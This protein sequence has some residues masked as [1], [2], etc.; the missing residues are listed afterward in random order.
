MKAYAVIMSGGA[1]TRFWPVSRERRPKQF[2]RLLS[3]RSLLRETYERLLAVVD[4]ERVY[5]A[6]GQRYAELVREELPEIPTSHI[7]AEP[8]GKNTLPCI[9]VAATIIGR[10]EKEAPVLFLPSDHH[11]DDAQGFARALG[12]ALEY[13]AREKGIL[14]IGMRPTR[15]ETG[16]GYIRAEEQVATAVGRI[17]KVDAFSEKPDRETAI[18]F[19]A[20][21]LH[22]WNSGIF[23]STPEVML[24]AIAR[25]KPRMS[26][27]LMRLARFLGT[28]GETAA[29]E[30]FYRDVEAVSIDYGI[31]EKEKNVYMVEGA[32]SWSDLGNW[33]SVHELS[34]KDEQGNAL[35][36]GDLLSIGSRGCCVFAPGRIVVM[37][38]VED[39]V[40]VSTDDALLVCRRDQCQ[41]VKEAVAMLKEKG[42]SDVL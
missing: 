6:T 32:F 37:I 16:F 28:D 35:L 34:A 24:G 8:V 2:L 33:Q 19:L 30:E 26:Q 38:G 10:I 21:G 1:G 3:G 5:V 11:V 17:F 15:P 13:C 40:A 31:M 41:D 22:Y 9:G 4:R 7:L 23:A 12:L 42:L 25:H 29:L 36:S 39:L 20:T 14:T 27:G 18:S